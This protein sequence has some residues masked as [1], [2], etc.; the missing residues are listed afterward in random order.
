MHT[1]KDKVV[2]HANMQIL[3]ASAST[4]G[5]TIGKRGDRGGGL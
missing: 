4:G 1:D 2:A 3:A 5:G